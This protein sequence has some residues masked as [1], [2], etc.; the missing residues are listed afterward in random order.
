VEFTPLVTTT[1]DMLVRESLSRNLRNRRAVARYVEPHRFAE[2]KR[3]QKERGL[4]KAGAAQL[5]RGS[6]NWLGV[7]SGSR[8]AVFCCNGIEV[9]RDITAAILRKKARQVKDGQSVAIAN[10]LE[11][12]SRE[13]AAWMTWQT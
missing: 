8:K 6:S 11:G 4:A 13:V 10:V 3:Q 2:H 12:T 5:R 7:S 9:R 1:A